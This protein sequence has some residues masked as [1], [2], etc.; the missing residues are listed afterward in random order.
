[1]HRIVFVRPGVAYCVAIA[2]GVAACSSQ[3]GGV[4]DAGPPGDALVESS[5]A[6]DDSSSVG[7]DA[8]TAPSLDGSRD[9]S[10]CAGVATGHAGTAQSAGFSGSDSAYAALYAVTCAN[11]QTCADACVSAGGTNS[12]CS[13]G[14]SC[15]PDG[16]GPDTCLPPTYWTNT[17][18]ATSQSLLTTSAAELILVTD[19]YE[20][21]LVVTGFGLTV[22][23]DAVIKGI[24][25][26]VRREADDGFAVDDVVE[27]LQGGAVMGL[28]E[29]Q[30]GMWPTSLIYSTY[31]GPTD[32][33]GASWSPADVRASGFGIVI[34]PRYTGPA[35]GNDRAHIDSVAATVSY[36]APCE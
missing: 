5:A 9:S 21:S 36:A 31:G 22:P 19:G 33:W 30:V 23:D 17:A 3:S 10:D 11:A 18:G 2:F 29:A 26:Q 13:D 7:Q 1:M 25:F 14:S 16:D 32:T 15:L 12:S 34:T 6:G 27:V 35:N 28:N 4:R 8:N 20:D 24:E